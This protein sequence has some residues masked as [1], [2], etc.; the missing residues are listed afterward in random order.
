MALLL[1]VGVGVGTIGWVTDAAMAE[2]RRTATAD[3]DDGTSD[4][5]GWSTELEADPGPED[6]RI[7]LGDDLAGG[8]PVP[9]GVESVATTTGRDGAARGNG[10]H[11]TPTPAPARR[12]SGTSRE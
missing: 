4:L 9:G 5:G 3:A 12:T 10:A 2:S 8:S 7:E 11:A 6:A 1:S